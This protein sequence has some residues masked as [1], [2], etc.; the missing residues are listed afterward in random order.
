M[1]AFMCE[2][3]DWVEASDVDLSGRLNPDEAQAAE[4]YVRTSRKNDVLNA[5]AA[6][7]LAKEGQ[8]ESDLGIVKDIKYRLLGRAGTEETGR[9]ARLSL[10]A[11]IGEVVSLSV[12]K[13]YSLRLGR[14]AGDAARASYRLSR[15]D[16]KEVSGGDNVNFN[17][18]MLIDSYTSGKLDSR[19]GIGTTTRELIAS[20]LNDWYLVNPDSLL[21][22]EP[23]NTA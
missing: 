15:P 7:S 6:A 2:V 10:L 5:I 4:E 19:G 16:G 1:N 20:F 21:K 23:E 22:A 12:F 13:E 9:T 14:H 18:P 8:L 11:G 17:I 3:L